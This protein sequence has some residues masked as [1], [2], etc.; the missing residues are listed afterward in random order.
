MDDLWRRIGTWKSR[1][2]SAP[3]IS[4]TQNKPQESKLS[5]N[6]LVLLGKPVKRF[7]LADVNRARKQ[8]LG[9]APLERTYKAELKDGITTVVV[10]MLGDVVLRAKIFRDKVETIGTMD[11]ENLLPLRGYFYSKDQKFL[12]YDYM[13]LGSLSD[14]LQ[15]RETPLSWEH[16]HAQN[17]HHGNLK[18]SKVLLTPSYEARVS[19]YGL[20]LFPTRAGGDGAN[21]A[22]AG[23]AQKKGADVHAFGVLLLELLEVMPPSDT[24]Y[25]GR[26]DFLTSVYTGVEKLLK[27]AIDCASDGVNSRDGPRT[28]MSEVRRRIEELCK[29]GGQRDWESQ[30]DKVIKGTKDIPSW[31]I[32]SAQVDRDSQLYQ[33]RKVKKDMHTR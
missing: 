25:N 31:L 19:D 15:N 30:P 11:H 21:Q 12:L 16:L 33:F 28:P 14:Q 4:A 13:P 2:K 22:R 5:R 9:K 17:S 3:D 26:A 18:S 6:E 1:S 24:L 20:T 10:K 8:K 32:P 27:L 7:N 29:F 23:G